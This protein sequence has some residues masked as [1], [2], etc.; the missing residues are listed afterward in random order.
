[1]AFVNWLRFGATAVVVLLALSSCSGPE[2]V[3]LSADDNLQCDEDLDEII[4]LLQLGLPTFDYDPA[5][6]LAGLIQA[7]DVVVSGSI[8][9]I[10]R[11]ADEGP[12]GEQWTE[13]NLEDAESL[14]P[15]GSVPTV[16]LSIDAFLAGVDDPLEAPRFVEGVQVV[17]FASEFDESPDRL[18]VGV[19]GLAVGCAASQDPATPIIEPLPSDAARLTAAELTDVARTTAAELEA[20]LRSG[21]DGPLARYAERAEVDDQ[22]DAEIS[23]VLSREGDCLYLNPSVGERFPVIWPTDTTW[24]EA[25]Q[26]VNLPNGDQIGL[27]DSAVGGGAYIGVGDTERLR[28]LLSEDTF[29]LVTGCA[30][31]PSGSFAF[32]N[33]VDD[34]IRRL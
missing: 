33:N 10:T 4:S 6:D 11:A 12:N 26:V 21:V 2:S 17:G 14:K 1:M 13:I 8:A 22:S 24:D 3:G 29:D 19:Q 32:V 16:P 31:Q 15:A 25:R 23:G 34:G 7:S 27:S 28:R 30:D 5:A 9:S 18:F 20:A